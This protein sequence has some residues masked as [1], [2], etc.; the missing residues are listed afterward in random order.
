MSALTRADS[1]TCKAF[2][3]IP[4]SFNFLEASF[5][6]PPVG[7]FNTSLRVPDL[8]LSPLASHKPTQEAEQIGPCVS[9]DS[10][11]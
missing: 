11:C 1:L 3:Y 7:P 10:N 9:A 4:S 6:L 2:M 8:T 5:D